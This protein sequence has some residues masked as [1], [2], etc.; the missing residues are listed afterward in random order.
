MG[1][2]ALDMIR[3]QEWKAGSGN[4]REKGRGTLSCL[5]RRMKEDNRLGVC[6]TGD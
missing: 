4:R 3:E 6:R 5:L 1:C 2:Q